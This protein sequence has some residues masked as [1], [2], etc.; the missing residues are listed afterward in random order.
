MGRQTQLHV[1]PKDVNDLLVVMQDK[2]PLE[3]ALKRGN[4]PSPSRV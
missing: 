3:V 4:S 1:L 2:E